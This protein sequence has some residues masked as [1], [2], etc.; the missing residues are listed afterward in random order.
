MASNLALGHY[1]AHVFTFVDD[2]IRLLHQIQQYVATGQAMSG[3]VYKAYFSSNP[4]AIERR[5]VIAANSAWHASDLDHR[6]ATA[7]NA[8]YPLRGD[9]TLTLLS[10]DTTWR[11]DDFNRRLFSPA[12]TWP[13]IRRLYQPGTS[14]EADLILQ[15]QSPGSHIGASVCKRHQGIHLTRREMNVHMM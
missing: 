13:A 7:G 1:V 5:A 3:A 9:L 6:H 8:E 2:D 12:L 10:I 11:F 15:S 14:L 4:P